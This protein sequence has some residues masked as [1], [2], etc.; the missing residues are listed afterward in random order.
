[1][2]LLTVYLD[3][4]M[5]LNFLVDFLL[6]LGTNRL[7][8]FPPGIKRAALAAALGAAYSGAC[9]MPGFL[10]LGNGLWRLVSLGLM[11]SIAFGWN[12]NGFRRSVVFLLLSMALGGIATGI[13][14]GNFATLV[15]SALGVWGLCRMGFGGNFGREYIPIE[16]F[17]EGKR[18]QLLALRDTGNTLRD[19]ITGEG[20][21][22][23][24]ADAASALTGLDA[25]QMKNPV[26]TAANHPGFRLIP[27]HAVGQPGGMLLM[28]RLEVE[29]N[30]KRGRALVA[31][32]P[33]RIGN[34]E[35]YQAL[36][37]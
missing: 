20:V 18:I 32:A 1:M 21:L 31:F 35:A 13:G 24:S 30:G 12:G 4:V 26:E 34:G 22:V 7:S 37:Y 27:Y 23:V 11:G 15:L 25:A 17:H 14:G 16:L 19:P 5:A 9:L 8:G 28:K 10:F 33:E 3:A 2:L 6:I 36:A 29:I